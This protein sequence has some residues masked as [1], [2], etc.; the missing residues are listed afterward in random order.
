MPAT[1]TATAKPDGKSTQR[2]L[3]LVAMVFVTSMTFID[4]T[5]V[6]IA[7]PDLEKELGISDQDV[8][9]VING[10]LL[11]LASFFA[12]AGRIADVYGHK[13]MAMIGTVVF[14]FSSGMCGL[15][16]E[17]SFA[18]EWIIS[19][20]VLQ[21]IGAALLFPAALAI[22]VAAFP[23]RERG[24]ALAI[25]FAVTGGFTAIGPIAGGYLV[26]ISWRAIFW[27]NIPI[28]IIALILTAICKPAIQP[29]KEQ[30]DWVGGL[31]IVVGM[32]LS[33]LGFQQASSWGWLSP[34]TLGCIIVGLAVVAFFV[35]FEIRQAHPLIRMTIFKD[36]AFVADNF[37]LFVAMMTF[38]PVFFFMSMYAQIVLGYSSQD[39]GM[40][41]M[42]FFLGF[43]V[44]S[45][46]G[47]ALLDRVGSKLPMILGCA[48]GAVGYAVWAYQTT[49][50]SANSITPWIIMA[51]A[52]IGLLL[53]PASTDAVNRAIDASYGEVT[54]IT[55]TLRNYGSALG[56][57]ILGTIMLNSAD[58]RFISTLTGLGMTEQQA[59]TF[60]ASSANATSGGGAP[61]N[62]PESIQE[63]VMAA[64]QL[65]FAQ[66]IQLVL[67]C[68]AGIMVVALLIAFVHPGGK[69]AIP[70][71]EQ[72]EAV[73]AKAA[74]GSPAK[75]LIKRLIIFL[76]IFA[77]IY[78]L[79][80]L[81]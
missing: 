56:M 38:V 9:W 50:M 14:A 59:E 21:G 40:F 6:S 81:L 78:A 8:Q 31:I 20:R 69:V 3:P 49:A 53:G 4:M 11:A 75:E 27:I 46:V 25:F 29:K 1:A 26:E 57:A 10:Y 79:V 66:A 2:Y 16:P 51:G 73:A 15:T 65:D 60:V 18:A 41:L 42:W 35:W 77:I 34:A 63:K 47:G 43:V 54:G 13:R 37:V 32:A 72:A 17:G 23:V 80:M 44:A 61:S 71:D 22:V 55:Q 28:A 74:E 68:M 62:V 33:V 5:I 36:R 24:R 64:I 58:S 30:I 67:W 70:V 39:A 48:I 52:G 12:L 19:F 76:I 45:Q 7:A